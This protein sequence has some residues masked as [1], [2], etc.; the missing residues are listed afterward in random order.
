M[1]KIKKV[2]VAVQNPASNGL[3]ERVNRKILEVLR[4]ILGRNDPNWD[5]QL[6]VCQFV[7]N[8]SLHSS[9]GTEPHTVLFGR[10]A[11][12]PFGIVADDNIR[13]GNEVDIFIGDADIRFQKIKEK[14]VEAEIISKKRHLGKEKQSNITVGDT[15]YVKVYARNDLNYKLG[16]KFDGA[17]EV[18]QKRNDNK[19]LVKRNRDDKE[20][21]VHR[22]NMKLTKSFKTAKGKRVR[23]EDN[24]QYF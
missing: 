3:V 6:N 8:T 24:V 1:F 15:V 12:T 21:L 20:F 11:K 23:F 19:Y 13:S 5:L 18:I 16:P 17:Y 22:N 14:L 4:S 9:I 10:K 2:N 7:I